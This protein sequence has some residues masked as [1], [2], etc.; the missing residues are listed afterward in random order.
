MITLYLLFSGI[1]V[2]HLAQVNQV[3]GGS[4]FQTYTVCKGDTL[5]NISRHYFPKEDPRQAVFRL[6]TVNHL[7]DSQL[8]PGQV[9]RIPTG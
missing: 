9:L 5:W 4:T 2:H 6:Q 3:V 8:Y 1:R 7:R